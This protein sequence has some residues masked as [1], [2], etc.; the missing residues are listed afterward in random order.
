L[1]AGLALYGL[2]RRTFLTRRLVTR[3]GAAAEALGVIV[4]LLWVVHPLQTESVTYICQ[5]YESL[6]GMLLFFSIYA[7]A[8]AAAPETRHP[9][10]WTDVSLGACMAGLGVK[11]VM[12]V[13][14]VLILIYDVVF[15]ADRPMETLRLRWKTHLALFLCCGY[16]VTEYLSSAAHAM[17]MGVSISTRLSR[18][19]YLVS[20]PGVILHYLRLAFWP[21][22]LCLYYA[23]P[24]VE[25]WHQAIFPGIAV[26]LLAVW[27]LILLLRRSTLCYP[28]VFFFGVLAPTSSLLPLGDL[29]FE[30]R[31]Y[32]PLAAVIVLVVLGAEALC[33]RFSPSTG[34]GRLAVVL[35]VPL[36]LALAALS[37]R[38]NMDYR[39]EETMWRDV[40]QKGPSN[41]RARLGWAGALLMSGR[42]DEA[43]EQARKVISLVAE[44]ASLGPGRYRY[45]P[46]ILDSSTATAHDL[47]GRCHLGRNRYED[48]ESEFSKA[49]RT[50]PAHASALF[51]AARARFLLGDAESAAERCRMSLRESD[52]P[53]VRSF[54][55]YLLMSLGRYEGG[56]SEYERVVSSSP[57]LLHARVELAW[58]LATCPEQRFRDGERARGLARSVLSETGERSIKAWDVLGAALAETGDFDAAVSAVDA[59]LA[60]VDGVKRRPSEA[61]DAAEELLPVG[62]SARRE[63]YARRQPWLKPFDRN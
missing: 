23:W 7:F 22:P 15:V 17:G 28:G 61:T 30:H 54:L 18:W 44:N 57:G 8:R 1:A 3:Y 34:R 46:E 35:V 26:I 16:V 42:Y 58:F 43:E 40:V 47:L 48:A 27:T 11:E 60:L 14:P 59:G 12:V 19:E 53:A 25:R 32:A 50:C 20:Q 63:A 62:M 38:R 49:L 41:L 39:S 37:L 52:D 29:I 6:M 9:R 2:V 4:A 56:F 24:P 31:M 36:V 45:S 5:R 55:A 21:D 13:A 51:G 10:F 33:R